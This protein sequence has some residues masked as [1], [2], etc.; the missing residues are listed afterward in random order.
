VVFSGSMVLAGTGMVGGAVYY[1]RKEKVN[2][3]V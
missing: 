3:R 2:W 1:Q